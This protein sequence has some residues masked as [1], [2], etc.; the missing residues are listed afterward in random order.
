ME[1]SQRREV[2]AQQVSVKKS[3]SRLLEGIFM[4]ARKVL[5]VVVV[6]TL[7]LVGI[8][9]AAPA[10]VSAAVRYFS[11]TRIVS[12]YGS[13][14]CPSGY[15]VTGGGSVTLPRDSFSS[16]SSDEYQLTGSYPSSLTSWSVSA[17]RTHGSYSSYSGWKF[18]TYSYSPRVQAICVG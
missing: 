12:G 11:V 2:Q 16:Y 1:E 6:S 18:S 14:S 17:T 7:G 9:V 15:K 8:G 5:A 3:T 10:T 4:R 13:A